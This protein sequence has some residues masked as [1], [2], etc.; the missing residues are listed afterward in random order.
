MYFDGSGGIEADPGLAGSWEEADSGAVAEGVLQ[1]AQEAVET[2]GGIADF[3][4]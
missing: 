1:E 3:E 4:R 2:A